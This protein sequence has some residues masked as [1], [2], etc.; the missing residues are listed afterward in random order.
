M[1][2]NDW[3]RLLLLGAVWGASFLF[4]RIAVPAFGAI[5][6]AF[7]RALLAALG[8]LTLCALMRV[9]LRFRGLLASCLLLGWANSGVP[10]LL[11]SF[12][13]GIL[14]AGYS[15]ILNATTPIM[16][17]AIGAMAF[18][19]RFRWVHGAGML[20]GVS[21]VAVLTQIGPLQVTPTVLAAV[22]ACLGATAS[23]GLAGFLTQR[24]IHQRGGLDS[25][26]VALG[27]QMGATILIAPVLLGQVWQTGAWPS[28]AVP[29][30]AWLALVALGL[31]CTAMAYV[32]YI[33]LIANV[34][35]PRAMTVAFV[36]PAFGVLWGWWFLGETLSWGHALGGG[37]IA[38][39]LGVVLRPAPARS[40]AS[41]A[42]PTT[43]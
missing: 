4:L 10:F 21:G 23:Y 15:A 12:A 3:L 29:A 40:S 5:P 41:S 27:S 39:A 11:F 16:G 6:A 1:K 18:G 38:M 7:G 34:G 37:M 31:V 43:G 25:R 28:L 9:P 2:T 42:K 32:L 35:P 13:A 17:L 33:Q 8:L 26:L 24:L 36:I 14:P 20:L 30:S 22:L 19:E